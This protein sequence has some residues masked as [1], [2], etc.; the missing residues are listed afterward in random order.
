MNL[1]YHMVDCIEY[2]IIKT[3]DKLNIP[4]TKL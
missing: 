3:Y 2:P 1:T 4:V